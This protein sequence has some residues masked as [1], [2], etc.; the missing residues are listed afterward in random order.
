MPEKMFHTILTNL[1][2][3]GRMNDP[4][5]FDPITGMRLVPLDPW[6]CFA[7]NED[8]EEDEDDDSAAKEK[9]HSDADV[10]KLI[11]RRLAKVKKEHDRELKAAQKQAEDFKSKLEEIEARLS[12]QDDKDHQEDKKHERALAKAEQRIKDLEA[13]LTEAQTAGEKSTSALKS[14]IKRD[15]IAKALSASGVLTKGLSHATKLMM[16]DLSAE[17]L[18][19]EGEHVVVVKVNGKE[20][21]DLVEAAKGWLGD[22]PHF[23]AAAPPGGDSKT[24]GSRSRTRV[25]EKPTPESVE[26]SNPADLIGRGLAAAASSQK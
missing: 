7:D 2:G 11:K 12:E 17:I 1:Y 21:D 6:V 3:P 18:E 24:P 10:E 19:E 26:K 15:K 9:K 16:D 13:Q 23:A 20:T 8:E 25:T 14:H 22:N 5:S 4:M